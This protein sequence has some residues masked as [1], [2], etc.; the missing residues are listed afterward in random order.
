[1]FKYYIVTFCR[2]ITILKKYRKKLHI[3][4]TETDSEYKK[5]SKSIKSAI[6]RPVQ[7]LGVDYH[8]L[9]APL[10]S[11]RGGRSCASDNSLVNSSVFRKFSSMIIVGSI[12]VIC[13]PN[14]DSLE[15]RQAISVHY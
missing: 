3:P 1:M 9:V 8:L 14:L 10:S 5:V 2:Q 4:G 12:P 13:S 6:L 11:V 7:G 15:T